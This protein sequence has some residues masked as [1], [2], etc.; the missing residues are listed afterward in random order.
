[1]WEGGRD[2]LLAILLCSRSH[3]TNP[4]APCPPRGLKATVLQPLS[5]AAA[6][7]LRDPYV[8][9]CAW[10]KLSRIYQARWVRDPNQWPAWIAD[11]WPPMQAVVEALIAGRLDRLDL[12]LPLVPYPKEGGA[13]RHFVRPTL[14]A[15]YATLLIGVLLCPL[16]DARMWSFSFGG[17]WHSGVARLPDQD[18][19]GEGFRYRNLPFSLNDELLLTSYRRSYGLFRRVAHW[20]TLTMLGEDPDRYDIEEPRQTPSE[21]PPSSLPYLSDRA[22]LGAKPASALWYARMDIASA[23]PCARRAVLRERLT[24]MLAPEVADVRKQMRDAW[25]IPTDDSSAAWP[26]PFRSGDVWSQLEASRSARMELA[27]RWMDLLDGMQYTDPA[28]VDAHWRPGWTQTWPSLPGLGTSSEGIPTG[29]SVAA[30]WFNVYLQSLDDSLATK[31][32]L[33]GAPEITGVYFRYVDD[34]LFVGNSPERTLDLFGEA[35]SWLQGSTADT[36]LKPS[37][38]KIKPA[39]LRRAVEPRRSPK[40]P[41]GQIARASWR[42]NASAAWTAR[43][44]IDRIDRDSLGPFVTTLVEQMSDLGNPGMLEIWGREVGPR[45][46]E[47]HRL[48]RVETEDDEVRTDTRLAFAGRR[49]AVAPLPEGVASGAE[50]DLSPALAQIKRSVK[51]AFVSAPWKVSLLDAVVKLAIRIAAELPEEADKWLREVGAELSAEGTLA[52]GGRWGPCGTD[53]PD[54][55]PPTGAD[56]AKTIAG[57]AFLRAQLLHAFAAASRDISRNVVPDRQGAVEWSPEHWTAPLMSLEAIQMTVV[58]RLE[59]LAVAL[60]ESTAIADKDATTFWEQNAVDDV[61][62]SAASPA[63]VSRSVLGR[64][65][66]AALLDARRAP[67]ETM[68]ALRAVAPDD[69]VALLDWAD[70]LG[71][72]DHIERGDVDAAMELLSR[73]RVDLTTPRGLHRYAVARRLGVARGPR[74]WDSLDGALPQNLQHRYGGAFD[75][76]IDLLELLWSPSGDGV[77]DPVNVPAAGLPPG[78]VADLISMCHAGTP[79]LSHLPTGLELSSEL[80]ATIGAIRRWQLSDDSAP[81]PG[82]DPPPT[83]VAANSKTTR[84]HVRPSRSRVPLHPLFVALA[85]Q[86][87]L[88]SA[89][90]FTPSPVVGVLLCGLVAVAGAEGPLD[91]LLS[92]FPEPPNRKVLQA[93]QDRHPLPSWFWKALRRALNANGS[94]AP[95]SDIPE[96]AWG[97]TARATLAAVTPWL[98][99]AIPSPVESLN[100]LVIDDA[101]TTPVAHS[102]TPRDS[103]T[104]RLAQLKREAWGNDRRTVVSSWPLHPDPASMLRSAASALPF[105]SSGDT[106]STVPD[107]TILPEL[108]VPHD[109]VSFLVATCRRYRIGLLTGTYWRRIPAAVPVGWGTR[110]WLVNEALLVAP[111][112]DGPSWG[113]TRTLRIRKPRP[114]AGELGL[115]SALTTKTGITWH[116]LRGNLFHRLVHPRWGEFSVGIC[117]DILDPAPWMLLR[118]RIHHLFFSAHNDDI[119][120]FGA[121]TR[122]RAYE[123][124]CNVVLV[125]TGR[126]GGSFAWSPESGHQKE[127]ARFQGERVEIIADVALL[128]DSLDAAQRT[129][130]AESVDESAK[131]W[132]T[133]PKEKPRKFKTPPPEYRRE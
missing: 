71:V 100:Y 126:M 38:R 51:L 35:V 69:A 24:K 85:G 20:T 118:G 78:L 111:V 6:Q 116:F 55:T 62:R 101:D 46:H 129:R 125:N 75:D 89:S 15:E 52:T 99:G 2:D 5:P 47:L 21:Y 11:P 90:A 23:Y 32:G 127:I 105:R 30:T 12:Q 68:L 83:S 77:A 65:T 13:I 115:A 128:V 60:L 81:A 18:A 37:H 28:R 103:I 56:R 123:D 95:V 34:M 107:L 93:L 29:I 82:W 16:L 64:G 124:Y 3:P 92:C 76:S 72:S 73:E 130:L 104:V 39:L 86:S 4:A 25:H 121:V 133:E 10:K 17:R 109:A 9:L 50:H 117:S 70:Q 7:F 36:N 84:A 45:L 40:E 26:Y 41:S 44:C 58:P 57:A 19:P 66:V 113:I 98:G 108:F 80:A 8:Q 1:M 14:E 131:W 33:I 96:P 53:S 87:N 102:A 63:E 79:R 31:M 110:G 22:R 67:A 42:K 48:V 114:A 59:S 27:G 132:V 74:G 94:E 54:W 97:Y 43:P 106:S 112:P 119:D 88:P 49:L 61:V 122:T 120:L 91:L